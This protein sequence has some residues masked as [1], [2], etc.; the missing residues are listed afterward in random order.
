MSER[1]RDVLRHLPV[2]G[3]GAKR[4]YYEDVLKE[5]PPPTPTAPWAPDAPDWMISPVVVHD[6]HG[7]PVHWADEAPYERWAAKLGKAR[8]ELMK[9]EALAKEEERPED[10]PSWQPW[11]LSRRLPLS[12]LNHPAERLTVAER[13]QYGATAPWSSRSWAR[14]NMA[15][16]GGKPRPQWS[17]EQGSKSLPQAECS[18][19]PWWDE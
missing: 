1:R 17:R 7:R 9:L 4:E 5:P 6:V 12:K 3:K 11:L 8:F 2:V 16:N 14:E 10:P 18:I 13:Q 19:A 15:K